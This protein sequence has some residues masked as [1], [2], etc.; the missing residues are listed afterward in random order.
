MDVQIKS[1]LDKQGFMIS[2][3]GV[4]ISQ[5]RLI[6]HEVRKNAGYYF[7]HRYGVERMFYY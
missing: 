1:Y 3:S 5:T 4:R 2:Y 6:S 7:P